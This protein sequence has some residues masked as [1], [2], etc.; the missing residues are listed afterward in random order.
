MPGFF[1]RI[2]DDLAVDDDRRD[3]RYQDRDCHAHGCHDDRGY[4]DA[5]VAVGYE[6]ASG[7]PAIHSDLSTSYDHASYRHPNSARYYP[8][9]QSVASPPG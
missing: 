5:V 8:D 6:R 9:R 2:N 7:Y 1:L 4:R 3:D